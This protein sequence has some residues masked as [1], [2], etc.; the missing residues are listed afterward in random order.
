[1]PVHLGVNKLLRS[2]MIAGTIAEDLQCENG[3]NHA[4]VFLSHYGF[5]GAEVLF[6]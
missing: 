3:D 2:D 1:M 5:R 6:Q 4:Y